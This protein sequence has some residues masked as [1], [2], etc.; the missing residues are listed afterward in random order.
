MKKR[1]I[2]LLSLFFI[3]N[4]SQAAIY[5]TKSE[6]DV[7]ENSTGLFGEKKVEKIENTED[8]Y[9]GLFRASD[10]GGRPGNGDGIGQQAPLGDGLKILLILCFFFLLYEFSTNKK[11]NIKNLD[12]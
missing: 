4:I 6:S 11:I 7:I 10:P 8:N 1:I 9:G 3:M 5:K 2:I 12:N